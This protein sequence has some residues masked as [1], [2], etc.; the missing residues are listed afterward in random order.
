MQ[1]GASAPAPQAPAS[2]PPEPTVQADDYIR[3][4]DLPR[5]ASQYLDP[6]LQAVTN[7]LAGMALDA[8]KRQNAEVFEKYG[9]EVDI[10]LSKVKREDWNVDNL[11]TSV[12]IVRGR[13]YRE[14][15]RSEAERLAG[16]MEP[17]LR[18]TGAAA[19][20]VTPQEQQF[21]LQG[22]LLTQEQKDKLARAGVNERTIDEWCASTGQ[23]RQQFFE[24]FNRGR[25]ITEAPRR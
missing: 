12:D 22:D 11:S 20:P 7:N 4:A 21:S 24:S 18:S 15:V 6:R 16:Q 9:P 2:A 3:G 8:V 13:H 17:T 25:V 19:V 10:L 5:V 14:L 1:G 23:T